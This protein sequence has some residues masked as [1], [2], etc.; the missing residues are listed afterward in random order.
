VPFHYHDETTQTYIPNSHGPAVRI[1]E[2]FTQLMTVE[3]P[4]DYT[5]EIGSSTLGF[6]RIKREEPLTSFIIATVIGW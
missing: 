5:G 2:R 4:N 6:R 1:A 3:Q